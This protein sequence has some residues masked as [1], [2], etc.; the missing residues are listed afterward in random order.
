[1]TENP[2]IWRATFMAPPASAELLSDQLDLMTDMAGIELP[3]FSWSETDHSDWLMEIWFQ[4]PPPGDFLPAWLAASGM[5]GHPFTLDVVEDKDWVSES[6]K[7]LQPVRAGR[8]FIHGAH[9]RDQARSGYINLQID[10]GQA[11]GT[12]KHETT[13]GCLMMLDR[14]ARMIK[15]ERVLDLGTGSGVLG[16][17]S[18]LTWHT[19]VLGSDI[20]PVA[21]EVAAPNGPLNGVRVRKVGDP[22][23]G[24][25]AIVADGLENSAFRREGPFDLITAN[26][27]AAPLVAM[28]PA[29]TDV[30]APG[31]HLVLAGLLDEQEAM[32]R[33]AYRDR[34]LVFVTRE[35]RGTWPTLL[36]RKPG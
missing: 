19:R 22:G 24:F 5:A 6:Q 8:Y 13:S 20:D 17:A 35:R 32:V 9:D 16:L 36:M 26:I 31:G 15:P 2:E 10:A 25:A 29:I 33:T 14:L 21:I 4:G 30:L 34:G 1:M 18:A 28:A 7:L 12:G 27:L 23:W 11:F 3:S